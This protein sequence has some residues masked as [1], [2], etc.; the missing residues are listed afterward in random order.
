MPAIFQSLVDVS[1]VTE[2]YISL[3][4]RKQTGREV[5]I[6]ERGTH[7]CVTHKGFQIC[8]MANGYVTECEWLGRQEINLSDSFRLYPLAK[9]IFHLSL[10][11]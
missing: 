10:Y 1:Q 7:T 3:R 9:D 2:V 11:C 8:R 4:E 5:S 6:G